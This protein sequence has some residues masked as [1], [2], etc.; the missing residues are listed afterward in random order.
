MPNVIQELDLAGR[1]DDCDWQPPYREMGAY[2]LLPHLEP[3][4][5]SITRLIKIRALRQMDQGKPGDA[6]NT[7]RLGYELS[8]NVGREPI[9]ISGMVSVAITAQMN[10]ALAQLMSR[11][12]S[13]NLYWALAEFPARQA[14][15]R[16][17]MD[18]ERAWIASSEPHL[19][20][21]NAGEELS[22][23]EWRSVLEF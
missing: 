8:N 15:F 19:V 20:K 13:P 2:T 7:L 22:A 17:A 5:H 3:L 4:A 16:H 21:L 18:G 6:I 23:G 10:D 11:A 9:M 14:I 12:D 1:R